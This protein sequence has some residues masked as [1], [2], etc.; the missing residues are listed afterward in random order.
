MESIAKAPLLGAAAARSDAAPDAAQSAAPA[1]PTPVKKDGPPVVLLDVRGTMEKLADIDILKQ[2]FVA[3]L[4]VECRYKGAAKDEKKLADMTRFCKFSEFT[5]LLDKA[6]SAAGEEDGDIKEDGEDIVFRR[7]VLGTFSSM[8]E[9]QDFPIDTQRFSCHFTINSSY[10]GS[11]PVQMVRCEDHKSPL[12]MKKIGAR[13]LWRFAPQMHLHAEM[14]DPAESSKGKTYPLMSFS[15]IA[16]RRFQYYVYNVVVPMA[17]FSLMS[18]LS[19]VIPVDD[20]SDRLSI[21]L[22]LV[23]TASAYR[24]AVMTMLPQIAYLTLLDAYIFFCMAFIF[25]V[26]LENGFASLFALTQYTENVVAASMLTFFIGGHGWFLHMASPALEVQVKRELPAAEGGSA[27][28]LLAAEREETKRLNHM[29]KMLM[30][31]ERRADSD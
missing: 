30:Q 7:R 26:T 24:Y 15:A 21:S 25:V 12:N 2:T 22:M 14:S 23:L 28:A 1:A 8:F 9:L 3:Q 16:T 4:F 31:A 17:A 18:C 27:Q 10:Q 20:V 29:N 5:N 13:N 6:A 19:F 11:K